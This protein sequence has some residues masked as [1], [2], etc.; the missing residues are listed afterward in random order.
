LLTANA[1]GKANKRKEEERKRK[2]KK[3]RFILSHQ[4]NS[5]TQMTAHLQEHNF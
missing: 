3:E 4:L 2:E 5:T 1:G